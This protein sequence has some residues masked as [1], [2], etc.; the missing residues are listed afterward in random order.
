[1]EETKIEKETLKPEEEEILTPEEI[2]TLEGK[3]EEEL[4][5]IEK[6]NKKLY[7]INTAR[8]EKIL[9]LKEER[10]TSSK[11][12]RVRRICGKD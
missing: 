2:T 1:M 6:K 7:A 9:A 5:D 10:E 8:K 4:T 3:T 11:N 12:K